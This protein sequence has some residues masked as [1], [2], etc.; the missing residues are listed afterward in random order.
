MPIFLLALHAFGSSLSFTSTTLV[1]L[2]TT[3]LLAIGNSIWV[4]IV[5]SLESSLFLNYFLTPPFHSFRMSSP[6]DVVSLIFF[7]L[8]SLSV[9]VLVK[10]L[11]TRQKEIE[12]LIKRFE[13]L[14]NRSQKS[15]SEN[16]IL[17]DWVLDIPGQLVQK[18][19]GGQHLHF[20]P[21][22]WRILVLLVRAEGDLVSQETVLKSVWGEKYAN[23][24][25]Y[26]RL[27]LS[28]LRKKLEEQP[29]RPTLLLTESG[30]GYRAMSSKLE[31]K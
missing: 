8:S 3:V 16:Y 1:L 15:D 7:L 29:K 13:S 12:T 20:T 2:L 27:Y 11:T 28:Q 10:G 23:E 5:L 19:N 22:E 31:K 21:I 6:D 17:G 25:N 14:K 24:T 26:L 4:S 9:S 18:S 30:S